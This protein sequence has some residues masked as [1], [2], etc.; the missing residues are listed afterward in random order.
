MPV[1]TKPTTSIHAADAATGTVIGTTRV[2]LFWLVYFLATIGFFGSIMGYG[3]C[4]PFYLTG[5][6]ARKL[7]LQKN[8]Q[9]L[10][11]DGRF[12]YLPGYA[13]L[14]TFDSTVDES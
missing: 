5:R 13:V 10:Y 3:L 12:H 6:L 7:A 4:I 1:K 11:R 14:F 8:R 2:S 9:L